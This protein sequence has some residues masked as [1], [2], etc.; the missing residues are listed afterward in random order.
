MFGSKANNNKI[1]K[2]Q[3]RALSTVYNGYEESLELFTNLFLF[4]NFQK[5]HRELSK[6][7][8]IINS[9]FQLTF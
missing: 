9:S 1:N 4:P 3:K 5:R 2:W 8:D 6:M 7:D